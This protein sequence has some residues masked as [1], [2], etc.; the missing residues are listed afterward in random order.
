MKVFKFGGGTLVEAEAIRQMTGIVKAQV[1][2]HRDQDLVVVVSAF[3]RMTNA[4]EVLHD[5]IRQEK[6]IDL[7]PIIN[8][9]RVL[10]EGLF[11]NHEL[12]WS[13]KI[14]PVLRQLRD[15]ISGL[16]D[17]SFDEGY[18]QLVSF[19]E[20]LSTTIVSAF[21]EHEG[22]GHTFADARELVI[23]DRNNRAGKVDWDETSKRIRA[24]TQSPG[25]TDG[26]LLTQGFIAGTVDGMTTTLGREG[27]DYSAAIFGHVL[28]A[29][30]V[31][32]WKDVAGVLNA[33][34]TRFSVTEKLDEISYLEAAELSYFGAKVIHPNTIRPMQNKGIPLI[35][36]SVYAPHD[37][38]T[39]IDTQSARLDVPVFIR[40]ENQ[41]LVSIQPRDF[42]FIIEEAMAEIFHALDRNG[43][44]INLMQHGA[45]SLSLVFDLDQR[46]LDSFLESLLPKYKLLYNTGLELLTIRHYTQ[47]AIEEHTLTRRIYVQQ[48]SRKTARFVLG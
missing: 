35:V 24:I 12:V 28:D 4:F 47:E 10:V 42:S 40:K 44:R 13:D 32:I 29:D 45:L 14:E 23:T 20:I 2:A 46:K 7:K 18:D 26:L 34:P 25:H 16:R 39:R 21:W 30:E 37:S 33:D 27:S 22:L 19:G 11:G 9:H 43:I 38:G 48:Q 17:L 36:K 3:A 15:V 1:S 8:F 5:A 31:V 41:V 6:K